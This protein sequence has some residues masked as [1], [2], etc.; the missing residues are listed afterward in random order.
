MAASYSVTEARKY[1]EE[2]LGRPVSKEVSLD[3][4]D[5][6]YKTGEQD[7]SLYEGDG[8]LEYLLKAHEYSRRC[9][10][11]AVTFMKTEMNWHPKSLI[12]CGT[13]M[14][15]FAAYLAQEFPECDVVAT[16]LPS[17]QFEFNTWLF[18][19][20]NIPNLRLEDARTAAGKFEVVVLIEGF[21]H[22]KQPEIELNRLR[23][24]HEPQFI[25][26]SS[27]FSQR[28]LGH[29]SQYEING[30]QY[31]E[32]EHQA[33]RKKGAG[34]A[35]RQ[36]TKVMKAAEFERIP[37]AMRNWSHSRPRLWK[38][39]PSEDVIQDFFDIEFLK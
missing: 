2:F 11:T 22:Y 29:F 15:F 19:R 36:F 30:F 26:E 23:E 39:S 24:A 1:L 4:E 9:L 5:Q 38:H 37:I 6:W 20:L 34:P 17:R 21:E 18:D 31:V 16:N 8:Y 7:F 33:G 14:G 27:S 35:F 13:G 32:R 10:G 12:D 25:I 28:G 3:L